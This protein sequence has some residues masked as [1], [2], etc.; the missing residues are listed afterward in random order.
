[1]I[2][3][4]GNSIVSYRTHNINSTEHTF[5]GLYEIKKIAYKSHRGKVN[6]H[7][8]MGASYNEQC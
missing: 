6:N 8:I 2:S 5:I 4:I 7:T 3:T 1:M